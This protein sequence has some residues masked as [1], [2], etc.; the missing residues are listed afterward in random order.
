ML[1][2]STKLETVGHCCCEVLLAHALVERTDYEDA[3]GSSQHC[4]LATKYD[5]DI[6]N[7]SRVCL[8]ELPDGVILVSLVLQEGLAD[9]TTGTHS[10]AGQETAV[11]D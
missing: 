10:W 6:L 5:T 1:A 8:L 7:Y 3:N 11:D 9:H 4:Y 2:S